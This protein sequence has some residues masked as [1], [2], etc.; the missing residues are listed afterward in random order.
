[1]LFTK[2]ADFECHIFSSKILCI[3]IFCQDNQDGHLRRGALHLQAQRQ[4]QEGQVV[5]Q[6]PGQ[7][8]TNDIEEVISEETGETQCIRKS[9]KKG[10][11]SRSDP[12][13]Q[14]GSRSRSDPDCPERI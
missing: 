3:I 12:W 13:P 14:L 9:F 7:I 5:H 1:M 2:K 10:S 6:E 8:L 4:G 11:R